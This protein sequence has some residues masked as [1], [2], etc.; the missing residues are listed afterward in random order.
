[1]GY[2]LPEQAFQKR[3]PEG[4]RG[5]GSGNANAESCHIANDKAADEKIHKVEHQV[6]DL[7]SELIRVTLTDCV[8][9]ERTG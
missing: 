9:I 8:V 4:I 6:I 3:F 1:V 5:P 7:I 2:L